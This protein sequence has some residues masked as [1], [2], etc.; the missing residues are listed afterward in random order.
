MEDSKTKYIGKNALLYVWN[1]IKTLLNN[2]VD[3][4]EGKVLSTNDFTDEYK[5]KV[6]NA[7]N[8]KYTDL[9]DKPQIN[10]HELASGNNTLEDLG[11]EIPDVSGL[12]QQKDLETHTQN[13]T[14][15]VDEEQKQ[16]W[17]A[18]AD[19]SDIPTDYVS[20][21]ELEKKGYATETFVTNKNYQNDTQV[22]E[23]ISRAIA[24]IAGI[25]FSVV[26]QLPDS[27]EKGIIYLV[28]NNGKPQNIYDEYIWIEDKFEK[29]GTT[30]IDLSQYLKTEDLITI[31]NE[32]IDEI[33]VAE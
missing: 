4:E 26:E 6:D 20:E 32:E 18:K 28:S 2:K 24:G 31:T 5:D 33:I 23:A 16:K 21:S 9:P 10:N 17:D 11:I 13:S 14:I 15:H 25:D 19:K 22:Q 29:I 8:G 30:D 3:K 12:A 27:G 1:K 7:G